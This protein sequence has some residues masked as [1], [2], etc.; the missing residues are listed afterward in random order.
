MQTHHAE[1]EERVPPLELFFDLVFVFAITQV[2]GL[3]SADATWAGLGRGMLVLGALWWAWAAYAWLTNT[4]D[5]EEGAV[6]LAMF[7]AMG[8]M[9]V[10]SLA[11]PEAFDADGVLFGVAYFAVRALHIVLYAIAGRGDADLL[12]AVLRMAPTATFGPALLIVAGFLDGPA[13]A[14]LWA[15]ALA[16]DYLGV[17]V[18]RGEGWRVAPAHFAERH[19][20]IVIIALGESIVALGVGAGQ[21]S[22]GVGVVAG[23]L[24]GIA[25]V[26]A[27]WWAYFDVVAIVAQ[28]RLTQARGAARAAQA[29]DSYSYLHL[30]M[31]AGIVL[32]ALGLKKTLADVDD[33][34]EAVPAVGLCGGLALYLLAHVAFRLRNVGTWNRQRLIAAAVLLALLPVAFEIPALAALG[35]SAAVCTVLIAYEAIRFREARARVRHPGEA[36]A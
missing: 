1:R 2:T 10:V 30:P 4:L 20:L 23:A 26:A 11:V 22:L 29:R 31:V 35:L 3:L 16:L 28:R 13:Q 27:M 33:P 9:L 8:A 14:G 24:L 12:G 6:R 19:G 34:L 36:A 17:L 25:V 32:F 5:P 21:L 15:L 18:G 7:A